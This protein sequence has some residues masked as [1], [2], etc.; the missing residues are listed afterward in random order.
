MR[1]GVCDEKK[2]TDIEVVFSPGRV[3]VVDE[4]L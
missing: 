4:L 2:L 3:G 1:N